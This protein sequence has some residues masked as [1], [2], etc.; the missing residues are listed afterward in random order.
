MELLAV[1]F[2][3]DTPLTSKYLV[4]VY[5]E[6]SSENGFILTAYFCSQ[7]SKRRTVLWKR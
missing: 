6:I 1:R 3:G 5:R 7:F 2:Y 4:V